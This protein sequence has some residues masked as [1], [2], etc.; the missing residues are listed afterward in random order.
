MPEWV[1]R[2]AI[3]SVLLLFGLAISAWTLAPAVRGPD[4]A[5][6]DLGS[7][8]LAFGAVVAVLLLNAVLT[9]PVSELLRGRPLTVW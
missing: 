3:L 2:S 9:L 8:R 6:R 5:R 4:A 1:P 7:H